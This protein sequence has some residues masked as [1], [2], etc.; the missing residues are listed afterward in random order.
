MPL[1]PL[2]REANYKD[3][4]K[5]FFVDNL[6]R[7]ENIAVTF[8]KLIN[9]PEVFQESFKVL[10]DRI[11]RWVS[12]ISGQIYEKTPIISAYPEFYVCSRRDMEGYKLAQVRDTLM[13][14]IKE[15]MAIPFY[16]S[17]PAP[18][19]WELLTQMQVYHLGESQQLTAKDE[20]KFKRIS[21]SLKWAATI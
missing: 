12:I 1:N 16:R 5:K 13:G 19:Q 6:Y 18:I 8:D 11:D 14:L 21:L 15:T 7:T 10:D 20:T 2:E 17:Y 4:L 3:S 9:F